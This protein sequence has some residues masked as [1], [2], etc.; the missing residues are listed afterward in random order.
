MSADGDET[1]AAI[2]QGSILVLRNTP[3][4][5]LNLGLQAGQATLSWIVPSTDFRLQQTSA[6]STNDWQD[7]TNVPVLNFTNLQNQ[8][9]LPVAGG[10]RFFRLIHP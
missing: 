6:L 9:V 5:V 2:S 7:M 3:A 8:V 1:V 4:P 10:K